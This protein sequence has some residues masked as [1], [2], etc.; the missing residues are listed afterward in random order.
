ML[1]KCEAVD[2]LLLKT[3][4]FPLNLGGPGG[5]ISAFH[6]IFEISHYMERQGKNLFATGSLDLYLTLLKI[7]SKN[8]S[9]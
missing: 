1:T 9:C 2:G 5:V 4:Y 8:L 6:P 7:S 3:T